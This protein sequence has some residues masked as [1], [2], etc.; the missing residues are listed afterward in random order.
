MCGQRKRTDGAGARFTPKIH[1]LT[2]SSV[3]YRLNNQYFTRL[4]IEQIA[5]FQPGRDKVLVSAPLAKA[6]QTGEIHC[7]FPVHLPYE[8]DP[9][10][11]AAAILDIE[12]RYGI[13]LSDTERATTPLFHNGASQPYEHHFLH[14][15]LRSVL[16][17]LYGEQT[18]Q[19]FS[20]HSYRAGLATALHA[21]GVEDSIIQLICRWM[22]PESLHRYRLIGLREH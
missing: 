1:Y 20:F 6:D 7:P 14:R 5:Q 13:H 17:H 10:N 21:A 18:A 12:K 8:R 9:I 3:A 16:T 19:L 22:C 15:M 4:T 11:A 2:F